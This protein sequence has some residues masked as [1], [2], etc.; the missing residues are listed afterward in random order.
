IDTFR[1][2]LLSGQLYD[3]GPGD[4][5]QSDRQEK[6]PA[7]GDSIH[8]TQPSLSEQGSELLGTF[9]RVRGQG[10][11]AVGAGQVSS[12]LRSEAN[13][14]R[15]LESRGANGLVL[16]LAPFR[17]LWQRAVAVGIVLVVSGRY[18]K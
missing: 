17:Y 6:D 16:C 12:Q 3:S 18:R 11:G 1:W 9:R 14:C 2:C 10:V 4:S 15:R 8:Q 13:D 5:R 7:T